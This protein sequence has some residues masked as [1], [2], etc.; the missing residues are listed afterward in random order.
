[1]KYRLLP[2]ATLPVI[3]I[4][5]P[6]IR[7]DTPVS[8]GLS[9]IMLI[10][11]LTMVMPEFNSCGKLWLIICLSVSISFVY[12]DMMSPWE[13]VSKYDI[14]SF[15]IFSKISIRR[16]LRVP[17]DTYTIIL[18]WIYTATIPTTYTTAIDSIS[19]LSSE[20]SGFSAPISGIIKSSIRD[21]KK[22]IPFMEH[23]ME[24]TMQTT[25]TTT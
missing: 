11:V 6:T 4:C 22:K 20:K 15:S 8:T 12:T 1:M 14:G 25:A 16:F 9:I 7:R 24:M 18:L 21:C 23:I 2:P 10:R 13:W 3:K 19:C 17:W 5:T